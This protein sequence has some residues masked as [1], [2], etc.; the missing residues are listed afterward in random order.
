MCVLVD[1]LADGAVC[2]LKKLTLSN[3]RLSHLP[4]HLLP[5]SI[6]ELDIHSNSIT[7]LPDE[8]HRL[9]QLRLLTINRNGIRELPP[10]L[11]SCT[12]LE[13]FFASDNNIEDISVVMSMRHLSHMTINRNRSPSPSTQ[14]IHTRWL[15]HNIFEHMHAY[16]HLH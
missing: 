5:P 6:T 14:R 13:Q 2:R 11:A 4:L 16:I 1:W 7:V 9:P 10:S 12:H 8:F 15:T 3:N